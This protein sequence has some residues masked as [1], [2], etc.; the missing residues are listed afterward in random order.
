[1]VLDTNILADALFKRDSE[2]PHRFV[3][4]RIPQFVD[5]LAAAKDG[6]ITV[7]LFFSAPNAVAPNQNGRRCRPWHNRSRQARL[8]SP[9]AL[10]PTDQAEL[11]MS[12]VLL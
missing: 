4:K 9:T 2:W 11:T 8:Q 6:D 3:E 5:W 12:E 1:M 7:Y 10:P